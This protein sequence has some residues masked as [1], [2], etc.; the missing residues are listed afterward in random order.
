MVLSK[1]DDLVGLRARVS[2]Q[3]ASQ[4]SLGSVSG[5]SI[6]GHVIDELDGS[7]QIL[8]ED[9]IRAARGG[10]CVTGVSQE[11]AHA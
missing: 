3:P 11:E 9:A 8:A 10:S 7:P 4:S 5:G 1:W 6:Y 2:S